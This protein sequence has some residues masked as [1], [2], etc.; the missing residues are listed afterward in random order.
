MWGE[1][2]LLLGVILLKVI[3]DFVFLVQS[4]VHISFGITGFKGM[5]RWMILA[6]PRLDGGTDAADASFSSIYCMRES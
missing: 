2:V 4:F 3:P 6:N 1:L 5:R